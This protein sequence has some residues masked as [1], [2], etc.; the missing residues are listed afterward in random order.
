MKKNESETSEQEEG[1]R[2]REF[3]HKL[4]VKH[5]KETWLLPWGRRVRPGVSYTDACSGPSHGGQLWP[6]NAVG[7]EAPR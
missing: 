1:E 7:Y 5:C 3:E 2:W 4:A 6:R